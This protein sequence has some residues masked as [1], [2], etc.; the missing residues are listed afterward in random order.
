MFGISRSTVKIF[1]R[2]A[3]QSNSWH[4]IALPL[5]RTPSLLIAFLAFTIGASFAA[6]LPAPIAAALK[7]AKIP[8]SAVALYVQDLG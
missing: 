3:R 4:G 6:D 1:I 2:E 7:Q 8:E 5:L